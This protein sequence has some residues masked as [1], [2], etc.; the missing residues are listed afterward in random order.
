MQG[1]EKIRQIRKNPW[2]LEKLVFTRKN[3]KNGEK[4][5]FFKIA[6]CLKSMLNYWQIK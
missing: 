1:W 2:E 5:P 6:T 3:G 4:M